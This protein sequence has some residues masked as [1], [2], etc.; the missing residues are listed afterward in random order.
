MSQYGLSSEDGRWLRGLGVPPEL[1][2]EIANK[3]SLIHAQHGRS[4]EEM[5][6]KLSRNIFIKE[7][8][9]NRLRDKLYGRD[10]GGPR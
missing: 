5:H 4:Y 9:I 1:E 10:E 2:R 6:R 7:Q 8:E 3:I